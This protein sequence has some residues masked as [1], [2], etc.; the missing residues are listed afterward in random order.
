[1]PRSGGES[2]QLGNQFEAVWTVDAVIDVFLG[3]FK[4][5][6]DAT[7]KDA[8]AEVNQRYLSVTEKEPINSAQIAREVVAQIMDIV[9]GGSH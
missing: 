4:S 6:T 9:V 5:I 7:V 3:A 2:E 8:V 1:M